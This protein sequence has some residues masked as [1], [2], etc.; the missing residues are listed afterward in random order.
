[1]FGKFDV[2]TFNVQSIPSSVFWTNMQGEAANQKKD[3]TGKFS[4]YLYEFWKNWNELKE[5]SRP[6]KLPKYAL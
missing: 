1:M 2:W 4:I 5:G 6:E 3:K